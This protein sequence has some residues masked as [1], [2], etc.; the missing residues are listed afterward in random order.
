MTVIELSDQQAAALKARAAAQG[1]SLEQ[2]LQKLAGEEVGDF[3]PKSTREVV[4]RIL[5]LQ[6]GVKPDPQ[7]RTVR[8]YINRDRS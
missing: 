7:V 1:L 6:H 3:A 5:Q 4:E 8:D 2:W